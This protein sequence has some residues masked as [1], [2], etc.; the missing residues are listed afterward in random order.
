MHRGS[1]TGGVGSPTSSA[2]NKGEER[3][4]DAVEH[5]VT[6]FENGTLNPQQLIQ[7]LLVALAP[8]QPGGA[9]ACRHVNHVH[10]SRSSAE[11]RDAERYRR[12]K[13]DGVLF[14][15]ARWN[16]LLWIDCNGKGGD[17]RTVPRLPSRTASWDSSSS[18][19]PRCTTFASVWRLLHRRGSRATAEGFPGIQAAHLS[20]RGTLL[21]RSRRDSG[22]G[23]WDGLSWA[24]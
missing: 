13:I 3:M 20:G 17:S 23:F 16:D 4:Q 11:S 24:A 18:G 8:S 2:P 22:A 14:P 10:L 9:C 6:L 19:E 15:A 21:S 7:G 12:G 1:L 5:L